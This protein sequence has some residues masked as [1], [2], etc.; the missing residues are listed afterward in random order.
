[1]RCHQSVDYHV[2]VYLQG[3]AVPVQ[4]YHFQFQSVLNFQCFTFFF[5]FSNLIKVFKSIRFSYII[6][7]RA[8]ILDCISFASLEK[9]ISFH[10]YV[11]SVCNFY[12]VW[13]V[14]V[15]A[16][17]NSINF[18]PCCLNNSVKINLFNTYGIVSIITQ[19]SCLFQ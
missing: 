19:S 12:I 3:L 11:I 13:L 8:S 18:F 9:F 5:K 2:V 7:C 1:M 15:E 17:F 14:N 4:C 10:F 6:S 16:E